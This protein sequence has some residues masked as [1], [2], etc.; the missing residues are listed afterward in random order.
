MSFDL[1][2]LYSLLPSIYRIRDASWDNGLSRNKPLEDLLEVIADQ[3]AVLEESIA[4]LYDDHFIE[5]CAPDLVPYVGDLVGARGL[6]PLTGTTFSQRAQV[7]NTLAYRRR[8]GTA[9]VLEQL[10]RDVTDWDARVVE[11]FELLATTQYMNHLRPHNQYAPDLRR[12][13]LLENLNTPFDSIAHTVDVRRIGPGR[14]KYN[15]PN[16]GIFVWRLNSYPLSESPAF[17]I[18]KR[19]YMFGPLGN[20]TQLYN[21]AE[22]E[23]TITHLAERANVPMPLS[24]KALHA[25]FISG[26]NPSAY[27]GKHKS[28]FIQVNGNDVEKDEIVISDL[29]DVTG[30][31]WANMPKD[32]YAVDPVL[33]R[34]V[35]PESAAPNSRVIVSFHYGFSAEMGGGEYSRAATFGEDPP[36]V[37]HVPAPNAKVQ[38]ALTKVEDGGIVKI[39]DSGCYKEPLKVDIA[40]G[41]HVELRTADLHRTTLVVDGDFE[42]K[43]GRNSRITLNGLLICN[44]GLRVTGGVKN[45]TIR[46][47]TL[48]PGRMLARDGTAVHDDKPSLVVESAGT[49]VVIEKS[50]VGALRVSDDC[51]VKITDSIVDGTSA[52]APAYSGLDGASAGGNLHVERTT[53]IGKVATLVVE[54]ASN[55]IFLVDLEAGDSW[56]VPVRATRRQEGCVRFSYLPLDSEVPRRYRCQPVDQADANRVRPQFSSRRYG[57]EGYC[58]LAD[59]CAI[60]IRG[61]ACDDAEM[62]AFHDLF[63]LKRETNLRVRL[64]EYL[65]LSL[66]AG[67]FYSS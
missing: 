42:I 22:T 48:V 23:D 12:W 9:A 54:L 53:I 26:V 11:F 16:V 6:H 56:T 8:K 46:H 64:D 38:E 14:G 47:C 2:T 40:A 3:V 28:F 63:Q 32:K 44:G 65:R 29:S 62:G 21:L 1:R 66:E 19:R 55:T 25:D 67:I 24:R 60:E 43:G 61:G 49:E 58:Q 18:D 50:I 45:L 5:T 36:A 39:D 4:Q 37:E 41:K 17:K 57:D 35:L 31:K 34:I 51:T 7:A 27:Y 20:N 15:I 33:G 52:T 13:L 59:H 30:G 10:A